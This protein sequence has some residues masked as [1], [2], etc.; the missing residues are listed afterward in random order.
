MTTRKKPKRRVEYIRKDHAPKPITGSR[1]VLV[2]D[3]GWIF[4]GDATRANGR[5]RLTR[6][7]HVFSWPGGGF[8]KVIEDPKATK[9]DLRKIADVDVPEASE[10][11]C[12]PVPD[13]WGL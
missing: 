6:A 12:V 9:A 5:I 2:V 13:S 1:V 3:R 10:V 11:F 7:L 4:A 8:A